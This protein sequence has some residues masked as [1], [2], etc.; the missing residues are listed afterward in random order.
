MSP[1]R[2]FDTGNLYT[3][4]E[5]RK[6]LGISPSTLTSLVDKG[7]IEKVTPVG[8]TNGF[9]TKSSVDEYQ[10]QQVLFEQAYK[11]KKE[12]KL[13]VR[14]ASGEDQPGILDMEKRV[15]GATLPLDRRIEY[16]K[17][18]NDID[19][20]AVKGDEVKGHLSLFPLP[21]HII[22]ALLRG[23]IR[24]WDVS[25]DDLEKYEP[26]NRYNLFVMAI[27]VEKKEQVPSIYAG[28][29]L[30]EAER[31]LTEMAQKGILV[32]AIYA[33]SRTKDGIYLAGRMGMDI[34]PEFSTLHR[35]AFVLNMNTSDAL[36]AKEYRE[37]VESLRIT[38]QNNKGVTTT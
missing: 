21:M 32:N 37:H 26:G 30:R 10:R 9:Y 13:E 7:I 14:K 17:K 23:D 38:A 6:I 15:L 3:S 34:I 24:G 27:A 11:L 16:Y 22:E 2:K 25:S 1:R 12:S 28:L 35:K 36:W 4:A 29:L 5:A 18:N 19:F 8:Y 31:A 33:T 20:I